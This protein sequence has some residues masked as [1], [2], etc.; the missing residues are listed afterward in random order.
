MLAAAKDEIV[1]TIRETAH[2]GEKYAL[3]K[4]EAIFIAAEDAAVFGRALPSNALR[5]RLYI[6][7]YREYQKHLDSILEE[8]HKA[9]DGLQGKPIITRSALSSPCGCGFPER[10]CADCRN[11]FL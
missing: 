3:S 7:T 10:S 6:E 11:G 8:L 1:K 2:F 5:I 9:V 4:Y